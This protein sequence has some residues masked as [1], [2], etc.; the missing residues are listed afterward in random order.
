MWSH[1]ASARSSCTAD[2]LNFGKK[3]FGNS[4]LAGWTAADNLNLGGIAGMQGLGI[5]LVVGKTLSDHSFAAGY[6]KLV[7]TLVLVDKADH[8]HHCG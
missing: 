1:L 7:D 2:R 4:G 3:A 8:C 6:H 5:E